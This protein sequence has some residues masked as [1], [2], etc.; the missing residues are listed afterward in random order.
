MK[1]KIKSILIVDDDQDCNFFHERLFNKMECVETI[2]MVQDGREAIDFLLSSIDG[3]HPSPSIIFL[4]INMPRM[5]GWDFLKEYQ[6]LSEEQK[7]KIVLAMLTTSLNPD[8]RKKALSFGTV[9]G[10]YNKYLNKESVH[11]I[12]KE[13]F[14]ESC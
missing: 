7:S 13:Y 2:Y 12:L 11:Q 9:K 10:F 8:D 6:L 3:E 5:D 1:K 4:D 14:P